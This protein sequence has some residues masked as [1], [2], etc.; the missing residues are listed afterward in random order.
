MIDDGLNLSIAALEA[1]LELERRRVRIAEEA[2][3][4]E[5]ERGGLLRE[6]LARAVAE[7]QRA[8]IDTRLYNVYLGTLQGQLAPLSVIVAAERERC[9]ACLKECAVDY[10]NGDRWAL[11]VELTKKVEAA[12]R[13]GEEPRYWE[14]S[15]GETVRENPAVTA[16]VAAERERCAQ[17][18]QSYITLNTG[19]LTLA[20]LVAAAIRE[21][22]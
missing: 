21:G 7:L 18:A 4:A 8:R 15:D 16:A 9:V 22:E 20:K 19:D 3:A 13:E 10:A 1:A 11:A 14:Q 6:A 17:K 5:R 2:L 12:I